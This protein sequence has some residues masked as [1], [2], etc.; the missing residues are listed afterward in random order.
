MTTKIKA[1]K[2]R[3]IIDG[4]AVSAIE[5]HYDKDDIP[6]THRGV[7][8]GC[9]VM[10]K[11]YSASNDSNIALSFKHVRNIEQALSH[12]IAEYLQGRYEPEIKEIN[13]S[14]IDANSVDQ[15]IGFTLTK[16]YK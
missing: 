13:L 1:I 3:L 12:K 10:L 5:K 6:K 11:D 7:N 8:F 9:L 14:F 15:K 16:I 2:C 4:K